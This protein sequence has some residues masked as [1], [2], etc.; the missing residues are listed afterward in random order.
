MQCLMVGLLALINTATAQAVFAIAVL[1]TY[2]A[3]VSS[4]FRVKLIS[5]NSYFRSISVGRGNFQAGTI[6]SR[7]FLQTSGLRRPSLH[8]LHDHHALLRKSPNGFS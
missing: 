8:D 2:T 6:L 7:S 3:Y 5:G 1:G 4:T